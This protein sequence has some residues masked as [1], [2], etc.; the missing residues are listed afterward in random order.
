[1]VFL[2]AVLSVK[3]AI[4]AKDEKLFDKARQ[5]ALLSHD[6]QIRYTL[7]ADELP[8]YLGKGNLDAFYGDVEQYTAKFGA[9]WIWGIASDMETDTDNPEFLEKA[10]GYS[11]QSL[12]MGKNYTKTYINARILY[13]LELNKEALA[14]ANEAMDLAKNISNP[15][16]RTKDIKQ[17]GELIELI[18]KSPPAKN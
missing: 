15:D 16:E 8:Y 3:K 14:N 11:E 18:K 4:E 7:C 10:L 12:K 13:K 17:S 9:D 5:I 2:K 1:M 6:K